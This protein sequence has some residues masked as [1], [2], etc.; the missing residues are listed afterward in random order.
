MAI[1]P[2]NTGIY[3]SKA[4][5]LRGLGN[6]DEALGIYD[7][8]LAIDPNDTIALLGKGQVLSVLGDYKG[9]I[10]S[11]DKML[12]LNPTDYD[13]LSFK[14]FPLRM[15]GNYTGAIEVYD[16]AL[17]L[18]PENMGSLNSKGITLS[19]MGNY[20]GAI[21]LFDKALALYPNNTIASDNREDVKSTLNLIKEANTRQKEF[22]NI[23]NM[24]GE[25]TPS[26]LRIASHL[27]RDAEAFA[28]FGDGYGVDPQTGI[29]VS[30]DDNRSDFHVYQTPSSAQNLVQ[31]S[32]TRIGINIA[33]LMPVSPNSTI[34]SIERING[35]YDVRY[36]D[37]QPG[38]TSFIAFSDS[39]IT[40]TNTD[41]S[42]LVIEFKRFNNETGYLHIDGY[43]Q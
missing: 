15:L 42:D 2:N 4:I 24:T 14:G 26:D 43:K 11:Y 12:E 27:I 13:A 30:F 21:Q 25:V 23:T 32:D 28:F 37:T 31:V 41:Y 10:E 5:A 16:K 40:I 36:I 3:N 17:A 9:S 20:T 6:N 18:Y 1:D 8:V 38:Y 19:E 22:P 39:P 7:K 33:F 29:Y 35:Q 34:E